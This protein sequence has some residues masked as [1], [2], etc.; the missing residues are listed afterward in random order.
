MA[1]GGL[2][3]GGHGILALFIGDAD[4]LTDGKALAQGAGHQRVLHLFAAHDVAGVGD[5]AEAGI[6]QHLAVALD[7]V[8]VDAAGEDVGVTILVD[9]GHG[10]AGLVQ[11]QRQRLHHLGIRTAGSV[12]IDVGQPLVEANGHGHAAVA[13]AQLNGEQGVDLLTGVLLQHVQ[14]HGQRL[15]GRVRGIQR[16]AVAPLL[17]LDLLGLGGDGAHQ[18]HGSVYIVIL[19]GVEAGDLQGLALLQHLAQR[20]DA[21]LRVATAAAAEEAAAVGKVNNIL[22]G[23]QFKRIHAQNLLS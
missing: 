10:Q 22:L 18:E 17:V 7:H 3:R 16:Y 15:L 4:G 19:Q 13:A 14:R 6:G 21:G 2:D 23:F 20:L 11:R 8:A 12:G 1:V 5:H 9:D